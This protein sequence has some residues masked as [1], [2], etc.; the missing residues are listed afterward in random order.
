MQ[1][2]RATSLLENGGGG[3]GSIKTNTPDVNIQVRP[4]AQKSNIQ[5]VP[6]TRN[7]S[8]Q[9]D[10]ETRDSNI[11]TDPETQNAESQAGGQSSNTRCF[12]MDRETEPTIQHIEQYIQQRE[13]A[14]IEESH[15]IAQNLSTHN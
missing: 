12:N 3:G 5:A 10:P 8:I 6:R 1:M 11:Q 9:P 7:S 4:N 2:L 15:R 14:R 13:K